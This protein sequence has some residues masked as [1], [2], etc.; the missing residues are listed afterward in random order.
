MNPKYEQL[1]KDILFEQEQIDA[2]VSKIK[3][4]KSDTTEP[5]VA[6]I[7]A[8]LMN[9]YNGIENIMKRCAKVYYKKLPSAGDWHKQLLQQSRMAR[10]NKIS[11]FS[12]DLVNKLYGYLAFRHFFIHG[13]GFKLDWNKMLPLVDNLEALWVEIKSSITEFTEK[14]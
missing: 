4:L 1:I 12:E 2:V 13:Y 3:G 7:A 5:S 8:Y 6:A 9:F 10:K 14:I 11:L